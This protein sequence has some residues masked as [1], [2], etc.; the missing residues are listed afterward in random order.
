MDVRGKKPRVDEARV[1]A[2]SR[3]GKLEG[4]R[5]VARVVH[6]SEVEV[7]QRIPGIGGH[8]AREGCRRLVE[9]TERLQCD[10]EVLP[11]ACM[12]RI[13]LHRG[14]ESLRAASEIA[15]IH[16]RGPERDVRR[17]PVGPRVDEA[18]EAILSVLEL[19]AILEKLAMQHQKWR[20][21]AACFD[22]FGNACER[23]VREPVLLLGEPL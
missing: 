20:P 6:A 1:E 12:V 3:L 10:A 2:R 16:P 8:G 9:L 23:G 13:G 18:C 11:P 19:A 5:R 7:G 22:R 14:P 4:L 17:R 21:F 15:S